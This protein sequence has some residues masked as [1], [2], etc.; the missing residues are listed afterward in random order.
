VTSQPSSPMTNRL[1]SPRVQRPI[2][3]ADPGRLHRPGRRNRL[4]PSGGEVGGRRNSGR[5]VA[6][7]KGPAEA[8]LNAGPFRGQEKST[9]LAPAVKRQSEARWGLILVPSRL[10]PARSLAGE[11][12]P[13]PSRGRSGGVIPHEQLSQR[14]PAVPHT[15]GPPM[16]TAC[17]VRSSGR[18]LAVRGERRGRVVTG[19]RKNREIIR[20]PGVAFHPRAS[21]RG[22]IPMGGSLRPGQERRVLPRAPGQPSD[23]GGPTPDPARPPSLSMEVLT[24]P[25]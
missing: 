16:T 9:A 23:P 21:R 18:P 22:I 25:G 14:R 1:W 7:K 5:P 20:P 6:T 12:D 11:I 24:A 2:P 10:M 8:S 3:A 19:K 4:G 17:S 15:D 13:P